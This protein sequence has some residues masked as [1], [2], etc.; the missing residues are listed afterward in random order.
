MVH[1][2]V[3][4]KHIDLSMNLQDDCVLKMLNKVIVSNRL[5][6]IQILQI[7]KIATI[8]KDYDELMDNIIW[9][10]V[11]TKYKTNIKNWY[12]YLADK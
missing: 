1:E 12:I 4:A 8:S 7:V 6:K 9:E 10:N 5:N 2:F 3:I 11:C